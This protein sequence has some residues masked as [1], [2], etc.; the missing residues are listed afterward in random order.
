VKS[1]SF[2]F[3]LS[4]FATATILAEPLGSESNATV[5]H[6]PRERAQSSGLVSVGYSKRRHILEIEF[7]NGAVYRYV[8]FPPSMYRDLASAESKTRYYIHNIRRNYRYVRVRPRI[9]DNR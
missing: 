1:N 5:S 9:K 4:A 3:I 2:L 8:N 6:I 7:N